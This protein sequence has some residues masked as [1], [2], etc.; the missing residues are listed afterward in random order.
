LTL[1]Y[2]DGKRYFYLSR[3]YMADKPKCY[4]IYVTRNNKVF[5]KRQYTEPVSRLLTMEEAE[6]QLQTMLIKNPSWTPV[7]DWSD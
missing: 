2:T 3:D 5:S 1:C 6:V 7:Y 4:R